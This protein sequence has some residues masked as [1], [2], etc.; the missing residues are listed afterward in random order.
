V[1]L[2]ASYLRLTVE[3]L[4]ERN[5]LTAWGIPWPDAT[6]LTLSFAPDGTNVGGQSSVLFQTLDAL[7]P[8]SAWEGEILRAFQ[9]WADNANINIGVM[10]DR[11]VPFG[12]PGAVQGDSRYGDIRIAAV[13]LSDNGIADDPVPLAEASPFSFTG[14][15]WSGT[16]ILNTNF[17]FS[18]GNV[19][20]EYDLYSAM[21]HEAGHVFGLSHSSAASDVMNAIYAYRTGLSQN[22]IDRLQALYGSRTADA[23]EQSN[24]NNCFATAAFLDASQPMPIQADLTTQSEVDYY[25]VTAPQA[26]FLTSLQVQLATSGYSLLTGKVS[27][28]DANQNLLASSTTTDPL[29]GNLTVQVNGVRPDQ[30]YYIVVD[31]GMHNEFG[32]GGYRL[33]VQW[34]TLLATIPNVVNT[35]LNGVL[36]ATDLDNTLTAA[37]SLVP[38]VNGLVSGRW[39]DVVHGTLADAFDKDYYKVQAPLSADGSSEN[40]VAMAWAQTWTSFN[41]SIKVYDANGNELPFQVLANSS[42]LFSLQIP[43]L[44]AGAIYYV[45]MAPQN[46]AGLVT[47]LL[48]YMAIDFSQRPLIDF[49][50]VGSNTLNQNSSQDSGTLTMNSTKLVEFSVTAQAQSPSTVSMTI[51]DSY[52]NVVLSL[53]ADAGQPSVTEAVLLKAGNYTIRYRAWA[54]PF[55]TLPATTYF[56]YMNVLND[57]VGTYSTNTSSDPGTTS[58]GSGSTT[59]TTS[60]SSSSS[61]SNSGYTYTGSTSPSDP[62]YPYFY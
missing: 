25:R 40:L 4:E 28:Y 11:G 53:T 26:L 7:G 18:V 12:S 62:G 54:P 42:G 27:V 58:S 3:R 48:Y 23:F 41:P 50:M 1:P 56:L 38:A 39:T 13:P 46:V 31:R 21:L 57:G 29:N 34:Q 55:E 24:G 14:T 17:Q 51:T 2:A 33:N 9:A 61:S 60:G 5:L 22:D 36:A 16:V 35:T 6:H 15:T 52:G 20:D 30:S 10:P 43:K 19:P 49:S 37:T 59:T 44:Q 32:I 47:N 8:P 45:Q